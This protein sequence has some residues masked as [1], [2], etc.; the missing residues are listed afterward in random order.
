MKKQPID[1]LRIIDWVAF[2][3]ELNVENLISKSRNRKHYDGRIIAINISRKR[4]GKKIRY[5]KYAEIFKRN[6]HSFA[7]YGF[8]QC[9]KLIKSDKEFK[10]KYEIANDFVTLE[11]NKL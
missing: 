6:N 4:N 8:Y 2:V 5:K 9:E 11:I 10:D 7:V 1:I 3:L